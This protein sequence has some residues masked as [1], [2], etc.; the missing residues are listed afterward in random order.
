MESR[1]MEHH[2]ML[3]QRVTRLEEGQ[4]QL[5]STTARIESLV[6]N[7]S[8]GQKGVYNRM[9]RPWQWGVVIAAFAAMITLATLFNQTLT[10]TV[11]PI[12]ESVA[13]LEEV[14]LKQQETVAE[15]LLLHEEEI[16]RN[17][18]TSAVNAESMRWLETLEARG[19]RH[20][21]TLERES[22]RH[23]LQNGEAH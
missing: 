2:Q 11:E 5:L 17:S 12:T 7:L 8:N 22:E 9:N 21:E 13:R 18:M 4:T 1:E 14:M 23:M 20:I 16:T 19:H 6:E 10:L 3:E 15:S